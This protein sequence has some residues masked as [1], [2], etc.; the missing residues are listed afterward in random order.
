MV[1]N[2]ERFS[3]K[4]VNLLEAKDRIEQYAFLNLKASLGQYSLTDHLSNFRTEIA[5]DRMLTIVEITPA[6]DVQTQQGAKLHGLLFSIDTICVI[7]NDFWKEP[8]TVIDDTHATEKS[9]F[10][11]LL[12]EKAIESFIPI[13]S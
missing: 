11:D 3:V 8:L 1:K 7:G 9:I 5:M 13:W 6:V 4:Y 2:V 10:Y 12:T